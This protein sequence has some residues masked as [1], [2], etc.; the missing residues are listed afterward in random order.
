M[1]FPN[2]AEQFLKSNRRPQFEFVG[3]YVPL[4]DVRYGL[5]Q[6]F[7]LVITQ[8]TSRFPCLIVHTFLSK[9]KKIRLYI[10]LDTFPFAVSIASAFLL[11]FT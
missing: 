9:F 3:C 10:L 4:L 2:S 7:R 6:H 5:L 11:Y 8:P 1:R